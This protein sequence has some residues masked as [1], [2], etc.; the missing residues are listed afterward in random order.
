MGLSGQTYGSFTP[1]ANGLG[2]GTGTVGWNAGNGLTV[3]NQVSLTKVQFSVYAPGTYTLSQNPTDDPPFI[4]TGAPRRTTTIERLVSGNPDTNLYARGYQMKLAENG[5]A[6]RVQTMWVTGAIAVNANPPINSYVLHTLEDSSG[7][8]LTGSVLHQSVSQRNVLDKPERTISLTT[9]ETVAQPIASGAPVATIVTHSREKR[10]LFPWGEE[11]VQSTVLL[12]SDLA[13]PSWTTDTTW[14]APT[15]E[16]DK[17]PNWAQ[18]KLITQPGGEWEAFFHGIPDPAAPALGIVGES[19][20]GNPEE[21]AR[22]A[23]LISGSVRPWKNTAAPASAS[24]AATLYSLATALG[25]QGTLEGKRPGER[26]YRI[27]GYQNASEVTRTEDLTPHQKLYLTEKRYANGSDFFATFTQLSPSMTGIKHSYRFLKNQ[28][29]N[30]SNYAAQPSD[31]LLISHRE[32]FT[33]ANFLTSSD[34]EVLK[35]PSIGHSSSRSISSTGNVTT[36]TKSM[37]DTSGTLY[38]LELT[39]YFTDALGRRTQRNLNG[40]TVATWSYPSDSSE[41]YENEQ[42][43]STTTEYDAQ[44][45]VLREIIL[46]APALTL[47]LTDMGS[48]NPVL[49][50]QNYCNVTEWIRGSNNAPIGSNSSVTKRLVSKTSPNDGTATPSG[51]LRDSKETVDGLGRVVQTVDSLGTVRDVTHTPLAAGITITTVIPGA[52]GGTISIETQFADGRQSSLV[53]PAVINVVSGVNVDRGKAATDRFF[54]YSA[55]LFTRT[56][57]RSVVSNA[58]GTDGYE[59]VG[60]DGLNR[61]AFREMPSGMTGDALYM[62]TEIRTYDQEGRLESRTLPGAPGGVVESFAYSVSNASSNLTTTKTL[63]ST[64]GSAN[65][66]V[67]TSEYVQDAGGLWYEESKV[68]EGDNPL[69]ASSRRRLLSSSEEGGWL[70]T[71][72]E[73]I[74]SAGATIK[75]TQSILP[76][77]RLARA[78]R[79]VDGQLR[80]SITSYNGLAVLYDTAGTT[81]KNKLASF[82]PLRELLSNVDPASGY[83]TTNALAPSTGLTSSLSLASGTVKQSFTYFLEND[84]RAG[85]LFSSI[86][87]GTG[88]LTVYFDYNARGKRTRVWGGESPSQTDY[89]S[90]GR[91]TYLH[92]W[93]TGTWNSSTWSPPPPPASPDTIQWTY[94]NYLSLQLS[95]KYPDVGGTPLQDIARRTVGYRYHPN[96]SLATRTWQRMPGSTS[97]TAAGAGVL[98]I[99]RYDTFARLQQIDYPAATTTVAATPD[100]DFT[101]DAAGRIYTRLE[102]GQATTTYLYTPWGAPSKETVVSVN[103]AVLPSS[104]VERVVDTSNRL[105]LLK[106][107]NST[108]AA[109]NIAAPDVDYDFDND[110]ALLQTVLS[111]S[112]SINYGYNGTGSAPSS[113]NYAHGA[114]TVLSTLRSTPHGL[115][116][117]ITHSQGGTLFQSLD[118][119]YD[120]DRVT[121]MGR[122]EGDLRWHYRYDGRGQVTSADKKFG[123]ANT[124]A[125]GLETEYT[126]DMVGNRLSKN[127]GGSGSTVEGTGTRATTYGAANVINQYPSVGHP[128]S[129]GTTWLDVSGQRATT[130]ETIK[131]N[132]QVASYQQA[133]TFP[134]YSFHKELALT[135]VANQRYVDVS[136]TTSTNAVPPVTTTLDSGKA[137]VP[138]MSENLTYDADGNLTADGRWLYTWD[139]ENR[140]ASMVP[141]VVPNSARTDTKLYFTYDGLSRRVSRR[142]VDETYSM[143]GPGYYSL[144]FTGTF[145]RSFTY[146][147]WNMVQSLDSG[148]YGGDFNHTDTAASRLSFVWGPDLGSETH[149]HT[150]WQKAGGVNGLLAV[151]GTTNARRQFPLMDRMGNV[152]GYRRA[153]SGS[154]ATLDAVFEYD[155]FGREVRST[156]PASDIMP[157]RFSTKYTDAESGLVYYGYR[158][159]D[160]DRGRW[161]SRDPIE[162]RG[163]VNLYGFC[164]NQ[165]ISLIDIDGRVTTSTDPGG[166]NPSNQTDPAPEADPSSLLGETDDFP[167]WPYPYIPPPSYD[168]SCPCGQVR[169]PNCIDAANLAKAKALRNATASLLGAT[170][171]GAA[172]GSANRKPGSGGIFGMLGGS[173]TFFALMESAEADYK[174]AIKACPCVNYTGQQPKKVNF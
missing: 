90:L 41:I 118:Y 165:A 126:Y 123:N 94:P 25:Y 19:P 140:L 57:K 86:L 114:T 169:D 104:V 107:K 24:S 83:W 170:G 117:G 109:P 18:I 103:T 129:G 84:V 149:G 167:S 36:V 151:L 112:R 62:H 64:G 95:K 79:S 89:D 161:A 50:A 68:K 101:Y 2:M 108:T 152:T 150:S 30:P 5:R 120:V 72:S 162:E 154:A 42:G 82:S 52:A 66:T 173:I 88:N 164:S 55:A 1:P 3:A 28:L 160:A 93:R 65:T 26:A 134:Y 168:P 20:E 38:P 27:S 87:A 102:A 128:W 155:A 32:I 48:P 127:Q 138:P 37:R 8:A 133:D 4:L 77:Q 99:Y 33:G 75:E 96:G 174:A 111:D 125:R 31:S 158:F 53:Y 9:T 58:T 56:T 100:V 17:D 47:T 121:S 163:G 67:T 145:R 159:Y 91:M 116:S 171:S 60:L 106:V 141:A 142:R 45:R 70:I 115:T 10:R 132:T 15:A 63:S 97:L 157:F 71:A 92:T 59:S 39:D 144:T 14:Y 139:A 156:G 7:G 166:F 124:F 51:W 22:E 34:V 146:D 49:P 40:R 122:G 61:I 130:T 135:P 81:Y 13:G 21:P 153:D 137:Y 11:T 6:T 119:I 74:E 69:P 29:P 98:T 172:G 143:T 43:V 105:D 110:T 131:V 85:N 136:I 73:T 76:G 12:T 78:K 16:G 54:D 35:A 147:G 44:G 148:Y 46:N 23:G 80:L 113:V